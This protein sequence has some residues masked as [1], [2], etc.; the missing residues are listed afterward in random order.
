MREEECKK[1]TAEGG[2]SVEVL[3]E[4]LPGSAYQWLPCYAP[5]VAEDVQQCLIQLQERGCIAI[6]PKM[7]FII[8]QLLLCMEYK[9]HALAWVKW[10]DSS[11][12]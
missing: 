8:P 5:S 7:F 9:N 3:R 2:D 4:D 12:I 11:H 6:G 10:K 1:L